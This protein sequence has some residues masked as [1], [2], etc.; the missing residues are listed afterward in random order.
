MALVIFNGDS[1]VITVNPGVQFIDVQ[2]DVY[3]EWKR[4]I[5]SAQNKKFKRAMRVVGGDQL[6]N[7][8]L[9][10]TFFLMNGWTIKP[11]EGDHRLIVNGNIYATDGSDII[12]DTDGDFKVRVMMTVSNIINKVSTGSTS[13]GNTDPVNCDLDNLDIISEDGWSVSVS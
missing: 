8:N 4:W 7:D 12:R 6:P 2:K 1:R 5:A 13:S 3:S 10:S 9:G 11:Y